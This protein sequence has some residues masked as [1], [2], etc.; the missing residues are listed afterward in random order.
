V[1]NGLQTNGTLITEDF[2]R[3]LGE[4]R[5]LVGL[6][7]DGPPEIHDHYR[8][9]RDGRGSHATIMKTIERLRRH[10][11]EFNILILVNDRNVGRARQIYEYLGEMGLMY[12]QY[13]PCV[14]FDEKGQRLPFAITGRQWGDFLCELYDCWIHH[15]THRVSIRQF[16]SVI[17]Y[18]V[19]GSRTVCS[20]DRT[21]CQYF[22]V[23][24]NGDVYPCDF[25][26]EPELLLGNV[27]TD[28]WEDMGASST[29]RRF[30]ARKSQWNERCRDCRHL[31][32]CAGDCPKHRL[33]GGHGPQN[34]SWLCEGW[35]QF[36]DHSM[37]GFG[38]L[39]DEVKRQRSAAGGTTPPP[40]S[41]E[42]VG[43]NDPC[44][45][46]SGLKYKRC[47]MNK[48]RKKPA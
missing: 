5:F 15:D 43:R 26:V 28:S 45:C 3:H 41:Y 16:D 1:A 2:A 10:T 6:S 35:E 33:F 38:R 7:L 37:D 39:A 36:Y 17:A 44:P 24:H 22:V 14:E 25:F 9:Y 13:I 42:N 40:I 27:M 34:L 8:V 32:V 23:E 4:Y 48:D 12:Q 21:C 11:V 30:G 20:M 46:G 31:S 29:Y 18:L 47:C 19:E